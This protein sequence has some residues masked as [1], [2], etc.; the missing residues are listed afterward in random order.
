MTL[1]ITVERYM[2]IAFPI[3]SSKWLV[4]G[5]TKLMTLAVVLFAVTINVPRFT[6]VVIARN[7][8]GGNVS[9]LRNMKYI[10]Q[11]TSLEWFWYETFGGM[12]YI[13]DVW[14]PFPV[15]IFVNVLLFIKVYFQS[16][17]IH[18]KC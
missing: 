8:D 11:A 3:K 1:V 10:I 2:A 15:L 6:S 12:H 9:S 7:T 17:I 5:K 18:L 13:V 16:F 14:L 4:P